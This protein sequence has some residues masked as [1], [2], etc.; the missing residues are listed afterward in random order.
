MQRFLLLNNKHFFDKHNIYTVK[1]INDI[2]NC[3]SILFIG[4]HHASRFGD[5][6]QITKYFP[7]IERHD[8]HKYIILMGKGN[9]I[10]NSKIHIPSNI[11][12]IFC[13]FIGTRF[14]EGFGSSFADI[15]SLLGSFLETILVTFWVPFLHQFVDPQKTTKK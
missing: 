13:N 4:M 8:Q 11:K 14:G 2:P 1:N 6:N 3:D 12:Y 9:G 5:L 10:L 15:G 7:A